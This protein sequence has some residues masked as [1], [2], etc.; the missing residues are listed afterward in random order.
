MFTYLDFKRQTSLE[1]S[2]C[3]ISF[4]LVGRVHDHGLGIGGALRYSRRFLR[5]RCVDVETGA[6]IQV[7]PVGPQRHGVQAG[8]ECATIVQL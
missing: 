4:E 6:L 1:I 5:H 8:G 2:H 3:A 7:G